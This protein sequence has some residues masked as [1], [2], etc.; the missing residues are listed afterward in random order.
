M[1]REVKTYV[2]ECDFCDN[3]LTV[4]VTASEPDERDAAHEAGKSGWKYRDSHSYGYG[5]DAWH[6][7]SL[8][9]GEHPGQETYIGSGWK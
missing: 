3:R 2:A 9:P 1:I 7:E 5:T 4:F 6:I 8:C